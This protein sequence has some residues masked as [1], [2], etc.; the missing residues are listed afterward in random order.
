LG[1]AHGNAGADMREKQVARKAVI[2]R[3]PMDNVEVAQHTREMRVVDVLREARDK[4]GRHGAKAGA[5]IHPF[6]ITR[7][8]LAAMLGDYK[9]NN[10]HRWATEKMGHLW[11]RD[12]RLHSDLVPH[13]SRA[14]GLVRL[15]FD[16]RH[17]PK[18]AEGGLEGE[19]AVHGV[20]AVIDQL[21]DELDPEQIG[22]GSFRLLDRRKISALRERLF[23]TAVRIDAGHNEKLKHESFAKLAAHNKKLHAELVGLVRE[24]RELGITI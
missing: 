14:T 8:R 4:L 1:A 21:N 17:A 11:A 7:V 19:L 16:P 20:Q 12:P 23:D 18:K 3:T 24:C 22:G 2:A 5:R 10:P 13:I 6:N 15:S 9:N